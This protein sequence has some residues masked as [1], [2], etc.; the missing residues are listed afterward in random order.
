MRDAL[1]TIPFHINAGAR[2]VEF[3]DIRVYNDDAGPTTLDALC[4]PMLEA[5]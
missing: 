1:G 2:R 3:V 5:E 4:R